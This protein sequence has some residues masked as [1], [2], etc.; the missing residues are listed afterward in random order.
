VPAKPIRTLGDADVAWK[1]EATRDYINLA[2]ASRE[3]IRVAQALSAPEPNRKRT[4]VC[5]SR[6]KHTTKR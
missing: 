2:R 4:T 3:T 1:V 6:P 5:E